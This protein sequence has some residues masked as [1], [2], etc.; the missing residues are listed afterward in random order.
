[1][2]NNKTRYLEYLPNVCACH[3]INNACARIF[4]S[5]EIKLEKWD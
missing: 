1:M 2:L 4:S 3:K 5:R